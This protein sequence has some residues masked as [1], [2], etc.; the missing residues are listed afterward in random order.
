M[1]G[2]PVGQRGLNAEFY[3]HRPGQARNPQWIVKRNI[4]RR[5]SE[6]N[7]NAGLR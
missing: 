2:S 3:Q 6:Q 1:V 4:C 5:C 7:H